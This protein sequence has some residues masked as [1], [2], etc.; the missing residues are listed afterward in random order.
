MQH[1]IEPEGAFNVMPNRVP[2]LIPSVPDRN[3]LLPY[4]ERIE[5]TQH[6]TNFGP[7]SRELEARLARLFSQ[8]APRP[9]QVRAVGSATLGLELALGALG[10]PEKSRVVVPALTFVA[11]LTAVIR[12]GHVPV[13]AD[14]DPD[15]W[16]LTPG[17]AAA[18]AEATGAH[19]VL[20]V[21]TFGRAQDTMGW[22]AF[23]KATGTRVLIDAAGAFGTQWA[24]AADVPVVFSMHATKSLT[25]GEG[26]FVVSGSRAFADRIAR[27][28]NFG[29][30]LDP[31]TP[32]PVG[33]LAS[34]GT[35]AKLSEFH[36]AV[37]LASLDGWDAQAAVRR[38][39]YDRCRVLLDAASGSALTWQ[40]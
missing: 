1:A 38:Q 10:L 8:R 23:R 33:S 24:E 40:A 20:A 4:L 11:T 7:L 27:D 39:L 26:G 13:V 12:A 22:S 6:Y 29:I 37:A 36:A 35:N 21:S 14:V 34:C 15:T 18:A 17:I 3:A 25:A 32:V 19:A 30:N 28:S 31:A 16:L 2:I 9:A 5:Q